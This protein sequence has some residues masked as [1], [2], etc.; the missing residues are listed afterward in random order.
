M[1][2]CRSRFRTAPTVRGMETLDPLERP[3]APLNG[4]CRVKS[5]PDRYG[6]VR[7]LRSTRCG[8][9]TARIACEDGM[10]SRCRDGEREGDSTTC[11]KSHG[12]VQLSVDQHG[13]VPALR[14][15]SGHLNISKAS[16]GA[17]TRGHSSDLR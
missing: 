15:T 2:Q 4:V 10:G 6:V 1:S 7:N 9:V 12:C 8:K 14:H 5:G 13:G 11:G 17:R 3:A 16:L